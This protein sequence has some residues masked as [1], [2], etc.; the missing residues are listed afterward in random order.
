M[1]DFPT[2]LLYLGVMAGVTYLIR[3]LPLLFVR[4]KIRS[5]FVRS[6][7]FYSPYAVLATMTFPTVFYVTDH[8]IS[9]LAAVAVAIL[10][11]YRGKN[12][13]IVSA[14]AAFAALLCETG[15]L[16]FGG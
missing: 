8:F 11:A 2:F 12:L 1:R 10:L 13:L 14:V 5:R 16:L 6:L 7:L 15:Y 3:L 9:G 4:K